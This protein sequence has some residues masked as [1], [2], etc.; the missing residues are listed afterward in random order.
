[1]KQ[2]KIGASFEG[3]FKTLCDLASI[4]ATR[5]PD[6]CRVVGMNK[7]IRV[8]TPWDWILSYQ[9]KTALIDTK[10][11]EEKT[12]RHSLIESHQ[13]CEMMRHS[14]AG[15]VA[16]YVVEFRELNKIV[17]YSC[18]QLYPLMNVRGSLTPEQGVALNN[19][20]LFFIEK[21][22]DSAMNDC[23]MKHVSGD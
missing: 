19:N 3:K 7:L 16:G 10:T 11:T 2:V 21:L 18:A 23:A 4:I 20:S 22:F 15:V 12:F 14:E 9:S 6:G 5:M 17:F 1:M 13:V 8:K